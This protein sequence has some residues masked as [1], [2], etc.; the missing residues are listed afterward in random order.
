MMLRYFS[1]AVDWRMFS[2]GNNWVLFMKRRLFFFY[3]RMAR[4]T[5]RTTWNEVEIRKKFSPGASILFSTESEETDWRKSLN[6]VKASATKNWK[7][8]VHCEQDE[9]YRRVIIDIILC[10]VVTSLETDAFMGIVAYFDKL[11]VR[12][13][14]AWGREKKELKEQLLLWEEKKG[15]RLCISRLR[16]NE[17]YSTES[18]RIGIESFGGT[19]LKFSGCTWYKTEFGKEKRAIWRHYPKRWTSWA[20]SLRVRFWRTTTWGNLTTSRLYQHKVAWNLARKYVSSSRILNYVLFSCE[21]A[22]DTEDRVF[23]V[24]SGASMHNAEQGD[25]SSDTMDTLRRSKPHMRLTATGNSA[26][27]RASTSFCSWSR[28]VRNSAIAR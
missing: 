20:K 19:H 26:N 1:W 9:K 2:A 8:L 17:F 15:P 13:N 6:S 3:T 22:R 25:L 10:V 23:I 18:W 5:V 12:R 28:S 7:F 27:E 21:G 14:P 11:M 16:S 24:Y 4:E